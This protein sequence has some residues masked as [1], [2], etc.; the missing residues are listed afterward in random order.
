MG[1]LLE[2]ACDTEGVPPQPAREPALAFTFAYAIQR[3]CI[4]F[5]AL[6]RNIALIPILAPSMLAALSFIYL[7]GN[8]GW[9][10]FVLGWFGLETVYGLPGMV[11]AM[12]FSSFP[13][14]VMIILA[15]LALS[16][17]RRKNGAA[18]A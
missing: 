14:A 11:L 9:L 13:H 10:K 8:Q 6:W 1:R 2:S 3:S 17:A 18:S 7:L 12:T 5:K 4:P 16:D 15:G